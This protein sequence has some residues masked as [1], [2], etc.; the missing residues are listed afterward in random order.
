MCDVHDVFDAK[1][2]AVDRR[3]WF[4]FQK[5]LSRGLCDLQATIRIHQNPCVGRLVECFDPFQTSTRQVHWRIDTLEKRLMQN[6]DAQKIWHLRAGRII[7]ELILVVARCFGC[8][9][10]SSD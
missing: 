10:T 6:V 3:P 9:S 4:L 7:Y 8:L 2:N 5:S 1:R